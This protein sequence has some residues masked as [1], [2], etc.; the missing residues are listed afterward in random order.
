MSDNLTNLVLFMI[1]KDA[2]PLSMVEHEGFRT[3][4]NKIVPLYKIPS[5]QTLTTNMEARYKLM[6]AAFIEIIKTADY[7]CITCDNWTD[8]SNQSYMGITIH[9]TNKNNSQIESGSLGCIPL[10]ERH[11]SEYLQ[12]SLLNIF[13]NFNV[14][15]DKI[16]AIVTDGEAAIKKVGI[17]VVGRSRHIQ[18]IAHVVS[19][20]LPDALKKCDHLRKLIDKVKAI[21][22]TIRRSIPASDKLKQLQ[23]KE[24]KNEGNA[25]RLIQDVL[26]R[27][28]STID[29]IERYLEL[30]LYIYPAMSECN[31]PID[32]LNREE[33]KILTDVLQMMIPIRDVITE[34]SGDTYPTCSMIIPIIH[35]LKKKIA[36]IQPEKKIGQDLKDNTQAT[37]AARFLNFEQSQLLSMS[38]ILDPRFK[39]VHFEEPLAVATTLKNIDSKLNKISI[40]VPVSKSQTQTDKN[41]IWDFHDSLPHQALTSRTD[42]FSRN[43]ELEQYL[44]LPRIPRKD[45]ILTYWKSVETTFPSLS[46]MALKQLSVIATTV[47]SE[48]LFSRAGFIKS[49]RRNKL[50]GMHLNMLLFLNSRPVADWDLD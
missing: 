43:L 29:M 21:T 39:K 23:L 5:R 10:Y 41:S 17:D 9:Y 3:L 38:T 26:T 50:T 2:E 15:I 18:C 45:N 11:T 22:T 37:M 31:N 27:W 4:M 24:G 42:D 33:V 44:Q 19:H 14:D 48:R 16:T 12:E 1:C 13:K 47:P 6:K 36:C 8:C 40:E 7:Y 46:K 30:E 20:L 25:L 49:D 34:I 35:C 28:T 32:I